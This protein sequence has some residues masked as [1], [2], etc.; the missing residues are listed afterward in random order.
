VGPQGE[1]L[2]WGKGRFVRRA[3]SSTSSQM[4]RAHIRSIGAIERL[5][6]RR[7]LATQLSARNNHFPLINQIETLLSTSSAYTRLE[8]TL[9]WAADKSSKRPPL[10]CLRAAPMPSALGQHCPLMVATV[11]L[12]VPTP[13]TCTS[14]VPILLLFHDVV[15]RPYHCLQKFVSQ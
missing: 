2:G 4:W 8:S 6:T 9:L 13:C 1:R 12:K 15:V 5:A 10:K 3:F 14:L 11:R 7:L